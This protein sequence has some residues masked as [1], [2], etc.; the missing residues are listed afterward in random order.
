MKSRE[1]PPSTAGETPAATEAACSK[2]KI[3]GALRSVATLPA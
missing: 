3:L 1:T 2:G